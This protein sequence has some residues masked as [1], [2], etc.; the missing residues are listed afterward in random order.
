MRVIAFITDPPTI[1]DILV[2]LVEP[3]ATLRI[4]PSRGATPDHPGFP[5]PRASQAVLR[6]SRRCVEALDLLA[7][8]WLISLCGSSEC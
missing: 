1:H 6:Y 7:T 3:M 4:A 2:H 5:S 8:G